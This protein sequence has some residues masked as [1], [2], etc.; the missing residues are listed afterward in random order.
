LGQGFEER[1]VA[2]D[3]TLGGMQRCRFDLV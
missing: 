3:A 2:L 1:S